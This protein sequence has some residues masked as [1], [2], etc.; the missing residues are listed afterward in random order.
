MIQIYATLA[1]VGLVCTAS[2]GI[3]FPWLNI[4]GCLLFI[5]SLNLATRSAHGHL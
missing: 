1:L 5:G 3:W 2:D 4:L